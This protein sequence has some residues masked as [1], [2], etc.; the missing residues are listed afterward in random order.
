LGRI[1]K[2]G[3][4]FYSNFKKNEESFKCQSIKKMSNVTKRILQ[5]ID[6]TRIANIRI[7][8]FKYLDKS[9]SNINVLKI[10]YKT[11]MVPMVYPLFLP[12]NK[13]RMKLNEKK[14]FIPMYWPNVLGWCSEDKLDY[15]LVEGILPLP[16]DHRYNKRDMKKIINLINTC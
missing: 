3:E 14:L 16:I 9:L 5:S 8:N 7:S 10:K 11:G 6:Y 1:E 15:S 4:A 2:D 12:N 13:L